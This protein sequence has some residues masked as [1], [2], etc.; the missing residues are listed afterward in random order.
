ML[1]ELVK[2]MKFKIEE[3]YSVIHNYVDFSGEEPILRKGAISAKAGEV[4]VIPINTA[5]GILLGA[6]LG[7]AE[8]N[9]SAPHGSG[10]IMNRESVKN[11]YTVLQFKNEMNGIYSSCIGKDTLGE[12]PFAYRRLEEIKDEIVATVKV[13]KHIV[14]IY[15]F[16]AGGER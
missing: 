15:N 16:K 5:D 7:N 12:A 10:R 13:K 6:G 14:P 1:D 2:G 11:N 4:V 9:Y 8:W 3:E